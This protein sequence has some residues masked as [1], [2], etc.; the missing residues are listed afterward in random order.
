MKKKIITITI[1]LL[2]VISIGVVLAN[3]KAKIDKA[4]TP[5]KRKPCDTGKSV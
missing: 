5:G 3:N 2:I 1:S 4:A